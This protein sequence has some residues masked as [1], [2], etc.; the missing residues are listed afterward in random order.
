MPEDDSR[1]MAESRLTFL[2]SDAVAEEAAAVFAAHALRIHERLPYVEIRH[3]GGTSV[4]GLLTSG[5]VDLH[6]R[7]DERWF[8][9]A[10][11]LLSELYEPLFRDEWDSEVAYF[12]APGTQPPVE[13][14]LTLSGSVDDLYHGEAWQR[15]M[16]DH[17]L[18]E[19]YNALK[20]KYEGGSID[21][22]KAAKRDLF[23]QIVRLLRSTGEVSTRK[24]R[25]PTG[26]A[27]V[28]SSVC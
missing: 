5:D 2:W 12:V 7:A 24:D 14:V 28:T 9:P 1:S 18:A 23:H 8:E 26:V 20:R 16:A 25:D 10:R 13:V 6:V 19:R 4:P 22:Y 27:T 3:H 21:D 15:I 17:D 11:D